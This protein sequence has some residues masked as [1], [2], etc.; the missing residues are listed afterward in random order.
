M[1]VISNMDP[2]IDNILVEAGIRHYFKFVVASYEVQCFKP[3]PEIFKIALEKHGKEEIVNPSDCCHIGDS[4]HEDY[5]GA[6]QSG[7][8]AILVN[9]LPSPNKV[10]PPAKD[11][12]RNFQELNELLQQKQKLPKNS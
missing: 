6:L 1:G 2:R 4:Y 8:N 12:C 10:D 9:E 5:L 11:W 7:W 3:H